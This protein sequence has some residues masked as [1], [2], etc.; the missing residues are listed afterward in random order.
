MNESYLIKAKSCKKENQNYVNIIMYLCY[1]YFVTH[2]D[3][4]VYNNQ[5]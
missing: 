2:I 5:L 3:H 4:D 1:R